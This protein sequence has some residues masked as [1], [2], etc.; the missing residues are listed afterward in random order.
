MVVICDVMCPSRD[1]MICVPKRSGLFQSD[2]SDFSDKG[3][4][5]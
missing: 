1:M 5:W 3:V 4:V 2:F